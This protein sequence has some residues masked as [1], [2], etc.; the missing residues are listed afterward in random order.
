VRPTLQL[1]IP[2]PPIPHRVPAHI[3]PPNSKAK[4]QQYPQVMFLQ[5]LKPSK[6]PLPN[7]A[8]TNLKSK[9]PRLLSLLFRLLR[10]R[11]NI[12]LAAFNQQIGWQAWLARQRRV[13]A[14]IGYLSLCVIVSSHPASNSQG[15]RKL[16]Q[17]P[18]PQPKHLILPN[19]HL[20]LRLIKR[21]L[22]PPQPLLAHPRRRPQSRTSMPT[23]SPRSFPP[24]QIRAREIKRAAWM[25]AY[26]R[27]D[28]GTGGAR[29]GERGCQGGGG[30][31]AGCGDGLGGEGVVDCGG[32]GG[33][34]GGGAEG[35]QLVLLDADHLEEAV[36]VGVLLACVPLSILFSFPLPSPTN[37]SA[38]TTSKNMGTGNTHNLRLLLLLQLLMNLP[39]TRIPQMM[40]ISHPNPPR[41]PQSRRR[42]QPRLCMRLMHHLA[43]R[44][45]ARVVE[46]E[47][48]EDC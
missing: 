34:A 8:V 30:G 20:R 15:E 1:H 16:T 36:L 2:I 24:L 3:R 9:A 19:K 12:R 47:V 18:N 22:I 10:S 33:E 32:G 38:N 44:R 48:H 13:G 40:G 41:S 28:R 31:G 5:A 14:G 21:T 7:P 29:D 42:I 11:G 39:Q 25:L 46:S 45:H 37:H 43:R 23:R 35:L 17:L 26:A 4:R 27:A 6:P